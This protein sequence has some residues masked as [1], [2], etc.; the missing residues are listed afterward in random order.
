MS[1]AR[2]PIAGDST[3]HVF[4]GGESTRHVV[5]AA[6]HP[7]FAGHFPGRPILP[8]VALLAEVMEAARDAPGLAALIGIAPCIAVVKFTAPVLPG[9]RI[10]IV[11]SR[12][13]SALAFEVRQGA[14]VAASGRFAAAP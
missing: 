1:A 3:R 2:G 6:D 12:D 10:D 13:A 5:I 8:G 11:F 7:A 4:I 14:R 9:S